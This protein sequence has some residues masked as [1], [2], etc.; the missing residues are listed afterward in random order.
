L[1]LNFLTRFHQID[2]RKPSSIFDDFNFE[3]SSKI[4]GL[5]LKRNLFDDPNDG[6][7]LTIGYVNRTHLNSSPILHVVNDHNG[8]WMIKLNRLNFR[9]SSKNSNDQTKIVELVTTKMKNTNTI[10]DTGSTYILI[11]SQNLR[12][13]LNRWLENDLIDL[14]GDHMIIDCHRLFSLPDLDFSFC[15]DRNCIKNFNLSLTPIEYTFQYDPR[16]E[17][18]RRIGIQFIDNLPFTIL[19]T[20]FLSNFH[21]IFDFG[22]K[23]VQLE[24]VPAIDHQVIRENNLSI[25]RNVTKLRQSSRISET[26][27]PVDL[28]LTVMLTLVVVVLLT[29]FR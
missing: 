7:Q 11:S 28:F 24:R 2:G 16:D 20:S 26:K 19:G 8:Y 18:K 6:G 23:Y 4:F 17:C 10:F 29:P 3:S 5:R 1:G 12:F 27:S 21:T 13:E 25:D 9:Y 22:K 14:I 15:L